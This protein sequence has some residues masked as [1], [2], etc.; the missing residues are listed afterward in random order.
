MKYRAVIFDLDGTLLNTLEDI[1][2][3]ANVVLSR[4]GFPQHGLEAYKYFVGDGIGKLVFRAIPEEKRSQ[5]F[6]AQCVEEMREEYSKRWANKTHPYQGIPELLDALTARGIKMSILSNKPDD[7]TK[8]TAA[9]FL[10]QWRFEVIQGE[11]ASAP[12]KP[13]P[14]GALRIVE[15]FQVSSEEILFLGDTEV[16]V[17]TALSAGMRPVGVLWGFRTAAELKAAGAE[18]LIEKADDLL[19]L[20]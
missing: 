2:D 15:A 5:E 10:S 17:K 6:L 1:A 14:A 8:E 20:I 16:D 3:S 11:G 7:F 19:S 18:V 4:Y 13:D 12:K 9:K